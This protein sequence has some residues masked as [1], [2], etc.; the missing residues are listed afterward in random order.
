MHN[1][2][3]KIDKSR[4]FAYVSPYTLIPLSP[5]E[6]KK[7]DPILSSFCQSFVNLVVCPIKCQCCPH[8]ETS[9]LICTADQFTGFY[10]RATL[11]FNGL[12]MYNID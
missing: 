2:Q 6:S 3:I 10:I 11:A 1:F 9:Q 8:V 12:A 5:V 4:G 7:F